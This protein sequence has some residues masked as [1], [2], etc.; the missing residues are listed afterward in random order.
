MSA[1][2]SRA[3]AP[4][5]YD[6][7]ASALE[8]GELLGQRCADCGHE[9]AAPKAACGRCGSR[10]LETVSLPTEGVVYSETTI[11]VAPAGFDGGSYRVAVIDLGEARVLARLEGDAGIGDSVEF[12]GSLEGRE[13]PAPLFA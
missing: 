10:G 7:W 13:E 1:D 2:E 11:A 9:T 8:D 5:S 12:V 6:E 4:L 3:S